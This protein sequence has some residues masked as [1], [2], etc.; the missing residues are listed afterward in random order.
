VTRAALARLPLRLRTLPLT[1]IWSP[2]V[3]VDLETLKLETVNFPG[4]CFAAP[5][6]GTSANA[7]ITPPAA[8]RVDA[9]IE[10]SLPRDSL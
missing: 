2:A 8:A 9:D 3:A 7:R 10:G 1:R 4:L 6:D 5:A